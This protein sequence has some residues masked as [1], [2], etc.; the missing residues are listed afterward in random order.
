MSQLLGSSA[1]LDGGGSDLEDLWFHST[2]LV[3][4]TS[5]SMERTLSSLLVAITNYQLPKDMLGL[6]GAHSH[7][8]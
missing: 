6:D 1:Q 2:L 8:T 7:S 5:E 3:M 4:D